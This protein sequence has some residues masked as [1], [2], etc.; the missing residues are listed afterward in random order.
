MQQSATSG[1]QF[2][3]NYANDGNASGTAQV[4]AAPNGGAPP[5]QQE[6][7][8]ADMQAVVNAYNQTKGGTN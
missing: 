2:L 6:Q 7:D 5:S 3:T 8:T 4:G 1:Q